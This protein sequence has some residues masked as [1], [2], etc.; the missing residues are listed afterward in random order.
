LEK[1]YRAEWVPIDINGAIM[2]SADDYLNEDV[3]LTQIELL[4]NK[5]KLTDFNKE[6]IRT[7]YRSWINKLNQLSSNLH[8]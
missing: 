6:Y 4:Y 5:L 8:K 1:I 2:W 3:F 7:Y